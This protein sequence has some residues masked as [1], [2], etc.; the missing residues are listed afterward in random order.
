MREVVS[1]RILTCGATQEE[2]WLLSAHNV[3]RTAPT[4]HF[5]STRGASANHARLH[6]C[7]PRPPLR[8]WGNGARRLLRGDLSQPARQAV[9]DAPNERRSALHMPCREGQNCPALLALG[10]GTG[11]MLAG[12][13]ALRGRYGRRGTG[14][15]VYRTIKVCSRSRFDGVA[16]CELSVKQAIRIYAGSSCLNSKRTVLLSSDPNQSFPSFSFRHQTSFA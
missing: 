1:R 6:G 4:C 15:V 7:P 10:S 11:D 12:S 5:R 8:T 2:K 14:N 13:D 16:M 3:R 9:L